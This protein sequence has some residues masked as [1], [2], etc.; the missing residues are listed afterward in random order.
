MYYFCVQNFKMLYFGERS[1]LIVLTILA[2]IV[3][4]LFIVFNI[5]VF[6]F[7]IW[8]FFR[9]RYPRYIGIEDLKKIK[10]DSETAIIIE[11][12]E[13]EE[14]F[15]RLYQI[16]LSVKNREYILS[17]NGVNAFENVVICAEKLKATIEYHKNIQLD[18]CCIFFKSDIVDYEKFD[19]SL[20]D[21]LK[22]PDYYIGRIDLLIP[23]LCKLTCH[24]SN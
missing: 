18:D 24:Y 12:D 8:Y 20:Q 19:K 23:T 16:K 1:G 17:L 15:N 10:L 2:A 14:M 9:H 11:K 13:T 6:I 5:G 22:N 21:F 7:R 4:V 3:C